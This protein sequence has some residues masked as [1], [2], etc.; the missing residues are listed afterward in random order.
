MN[1]FIKIFSIFFNQTTFFKNIKKEP[2]QI[3]LVFFISMLIIKLITSIH[4]LLGLRIYLMYLLILITSLFIIFFLIKIYNDGVKL[5]DIFKAYTY[6]LIPLSIVY[7]LFSYSQEAYNYIILDKPV[8]LLLLAFFLVQLF[9]KGLNIMN[10]IKSGQVY[11]ALILFGVLGY[12]VYIARI[13][14]I[15]FYFTVLTILYFKR[16]KFTPQGIVLLLKSKLGLKQMNSLSKKIPKTLNFLAWGGIIIGFILMLIIS[17]YLIY[18]VYELIFVEET[19]PGVA[20]VLPGI[21]I[22]GSPID[23]PLWY[24]I[25]SIFIV[26]VVHEF[27]H[28]VIARLHNIKVKS[29]GL[30]FMGPIIGAFI[31]PDDK[32]LDK[33]KT[34]HKLAV[35]G[36]GPFSNVIL[37]IIVL[38]ILNFA[39]TPLFSNML[40]EDGVKIGVLEDTPAYEAGLENDMIIRQLNDYQINNTENLLFYLGETKPGDNL[41]IYT[42]ENQFN[43]TL[44]E[45]PQRNET[46]YLGITSAQNFKLKDQYELRFGNFLLQVMFILLD[47][48][49]W[50]FII[51]LGIGIANLIPFGPADGGRMV[52]YVL[53][54]YYNEEK[55]K[56]ISNSISIFFIMILLFILFFPL[57]KWIGSQFII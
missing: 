18:N 41:T 10:Q 51:S 36:A 26:V 5:K 19:I 32:S 1:F 53:L 28:G 57:F 24:G 43:V 7:V 15:I 44:T 21:P 25:I 29:S 45:H 22:P 35:L 40:E 31:E 39:L 4:G 20:P 27:A 46:G 30:F 48:F 38:L 34:K 49:L 6:S 17:G 8:F 13:D 33:S 9:S 23:L 42:F 37:A 2:F 52:Y 54:K 3:T 12:I 55:A 47:F 11:P 14:V 50:L 56:K 16:K